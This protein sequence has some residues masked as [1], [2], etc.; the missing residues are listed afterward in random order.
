MTNNETP[1]SVSVLDETICYHLDA[2]IKP[3]ELTTQKKEAMRM[4]ILDQIN[5]NEKPQLDL[6]LTIRQDEGNWIKIA[7]KMDKKLLFVDLEKMTESYLLRLEPGVEVPAHQHQHDEF[8]LVLE[9]SV[10]FEHIQLNAGD[11][12]V[13]HKG[14][15]H[16]IATS[17]SG[18]LLY[19]QSGLS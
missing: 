19:L 13:A 1:D 7:P 3:V 17:N 4:R 12:H 2:A 14:S 16:G 8:C 11:Y 10:N 18:A 9:G 15:T 5:A 6:L